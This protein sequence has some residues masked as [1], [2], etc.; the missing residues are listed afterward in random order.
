M[1]LPPI[2][3]DQRVMAV[4]MLANALRG[5]A[6]PRDEARA[7]NGRG[8][9]AGAAGQRRAEAAERYAE[10]M[11]DLLAVLFAEGRPGAESLRADAVA[12]ARGAPPREQGWG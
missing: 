1:P 7:A 8:L 5:S 4:S 12:I 9:L 2:D 3:D 10:G 6:H 11:V